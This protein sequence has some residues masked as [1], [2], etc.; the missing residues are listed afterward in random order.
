MG[1]RPI[2]RF[3]RGVLALSVCACASLH[4]VYADT[5]RIY[6]SDYPPYS[7]VGKDGTIQGI[8]TDKVRELFNKLG[9]E[10]EIHIVPW[11]RAL[12]LVEETPNSFIYSIDR[13]TAR[14]DHYH[15][16]YALNSVEIHL[17]GRV[18]MGLSPSTKPA[19][20]SGKYKAVCSKA[21]SSCELL[22]QYGFKPKNILTIADQTPS[23]FVRLLL[24]KRVDFILND[25]K[26]M[27]YEEGMQKI[28]TYDVI[29]SGITD[30][31]AASKKA[32][33]SFIQALQQKIT[34][35]QE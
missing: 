34:L 29:E 9:L 18:D 28:R 3:V 8:S 20:I 21:T 19:T 4:A 30:Y 1:G 24:R 11:R 2:Y 25:P 33:P 26:V 13:L 6:T 32:D 10:Y 15:W 16:L 12:N 17:I 22:R 23:D 35:L 31:L 27:A 7:Y 14:E 5:F